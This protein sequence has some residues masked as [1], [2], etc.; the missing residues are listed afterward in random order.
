[1]PQSSKKQNLI[2]AP[3]LATIH[4]AFALLFTITT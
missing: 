3:A 2:F 1:M 4:I